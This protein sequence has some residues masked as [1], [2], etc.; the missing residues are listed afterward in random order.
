MEISEEEQVTPEKVAPSIPLN[1]IE[2]SADSEEQ[3]FMHDTEQ[4]ISDKLLPQ[5]LSNDKHNVQVLNLENYNNVNASIEVPLTKNLQT[6][7]EDASKG[8]GH[9]RNSQIFNHGG[10]L[11]THTQNEGKLM[12][13]RY[14]Q[15]I[16][17]R[18]VF[19]SEI[20]NNENLH[21]PSEGLMP[22]D[23]DI[24][25]YGSSKVRFSLRRFQ[26]S[27]DAVLVR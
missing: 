21:L 8:L 9:T 23:R 6:F 11:R 20:G 13:K 4:Y 14:S 15:Y 24:E 27:F 12:I 3:D 7:K 17:F 16:P 25:S 2:D 10:Y 5:V 1:L 18:P 19:D 26:I 22:R